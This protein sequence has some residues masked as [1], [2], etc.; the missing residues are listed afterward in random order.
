MGVIHLRK[1]KEKIRELKKIK[2]YR[3][4]RKS[5]CGNHIHTMLVLGDGRIVTGETNGLIHVFD[6]NNSDNLM[7]ID[8]KLELQDIILM[9]NNKLLGYAKF[10]SIFKIYSIFL[11][12]YT[13]EFVKVL[14][15]KVILTKVI[16]LS[17]GRFAFCSESKY[18][19]EIWK[20][21]DTCELIIIVGED[22]YNVNSIFYSRKKDKL[23]SFG[24]NI[25]IW[26]LKTY[27]CETIIEL[28]NF[29][30]ILERS[31]MAE[32]NN[33]SLIIGVAQQI[34]L[35]NLSSYT[36]TVINK[37]GKYYLFKSFLQISNYIVLCGGIQHLFAFSIETKSFVEIKIKNLWYIVENLYILKDKTYIFTSSD[38]F[39]FGD[40]NN[41][42]LNDIDKNLSNKNYFF[43]F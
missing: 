4:I 3:F 43:H 39:F 11:S 36:F 42:Y 21:K 25:W 17:N 35:I 28:Y 6:I 27:Q 24:H 32:L 18:G 2:N 20:C 10:E 29:H 30:S 14:E 12:T 40:K 23:L 9:E 41:K 22:E 5:I 16:S 7:T 34:V 38:I 15:P 19:V 31:G 13:C 8:T 33:N 26:N 37:K 1:N